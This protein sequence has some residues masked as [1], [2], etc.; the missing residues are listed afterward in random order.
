[1]TAIRYL[2][3]ALV[4]AALTVAAVVGSHPSTRQ[5]DPFYCV[6]VKDGQGHPIDTICVPGPS[7]PAVVADRGAAA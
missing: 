1:V 6:I 4:L 5:A 7:A 2:C 3:I